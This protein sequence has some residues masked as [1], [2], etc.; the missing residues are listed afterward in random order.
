MSYNLLDKSR[1]E[2]SVLREA[3]TIL[4]MID[5]FIHER[6]T[7]QDID[8]LVRAIFADARLAALN[9]GTITIDNLRNAPRLV[10]R[11]NRLFSTK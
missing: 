6:Q 9:H 10:G 1:L 11:V 2:L 5:R 3:D 7:V 8:G 4:R